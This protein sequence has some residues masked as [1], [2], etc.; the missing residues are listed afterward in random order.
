M[1]H[2][3]MDN[4]LDLT[5]SEVVAMDY[6]QKQ[7]LLLMIGGRVLELKTE[8]VHV[9]GRY[10]EIKAELDALKHVSSVVQSAL[11]AEQGM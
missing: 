1:I 10:A 4:P 11:K 2:D 5:P 6:G 9:S 7:D 8:F 3:T